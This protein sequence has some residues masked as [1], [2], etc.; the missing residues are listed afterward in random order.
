M[1][2][3]NS[4]FGASFEILVHCKIWV[5]SIMFYLNLK[6]SCLNYEEEH[7]TKHSW[8]YYSAIIIYDKES[9]SQINIVT[10]I[11]FKLVFNLVVSFQILRNIF[12]CLFK[13]KFFFWWFPFCKI[14]HGCLLGLSPLLSTNCFITSQPQSIW[15]S[16]LI[17]KIDRSIISF[18]HFQRQG[19]IQCLTHLSVKIKN[20]VEI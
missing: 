15:M 14:P 1:W 4:I 13:M 20:K 10:D 6:V 16:K 19:Y 12:L 2:G 17:L 9:L 18:D 3:V 11:V 7:N 8:N 5:V